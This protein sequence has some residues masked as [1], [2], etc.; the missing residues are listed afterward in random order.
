MKSRPP[1]QRQPGI[2]RLR[3][4]EHNARFWQLALLAALLALW[5][6]ASR[7]RQV[8]FFLGEPVE[9]AGRIWS[10]FMPFAVPSNA[11]FPEGLPGN[12]DIY[13]HLGTTLLE[14][15][16]AFGIGTLLGLTCG[17]WLALSR[18]ASLILDPYLKAA[19]SM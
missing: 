11:V 10:W 18:T 12:A 4:S 6:I 9:V 1:S 3:P 8:A 7:D 5:H 13:R 2:A 16:L 19:N 14:T 17:L 15:L